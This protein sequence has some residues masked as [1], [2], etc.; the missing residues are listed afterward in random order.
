MQIVVAY[1]AAGLF[2]VCFGTMVFFF[3][4]HTW[5]W[6][7]MFTLM[8]AACYFIRTL[9]QNEPQ[10]QEAERNET[11]TVE[12]AEPEPHIQTE[13]QPAPE[14]AT[15]QGETS[16]HRTNPVFG[17]LVALLAAAANIATIVILLY[18][19]FWLQETSFKYD[20]GE[21]SYFSG[22]LVAIPL[23]VLLNVMS[24]RLR[25]ASRF[26][27]WVVDF[28]PSLALL[29]TVIA[30]AGLTILTT[31][32]PP[33]SFEFLLLLTG[34]FIW[35]LADVFYNQRQNVNDL[36]AGNLNATAGTVTQG[37]LPEQNTEVVHNVTRRI[38]FNDVYEQVQGDGSVVPMDSP[39]PW[40]T[41]VIDY[42]WVNDPPQ[43]APPRPPAASA[44]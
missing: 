13:P 12:P 4:D 36:L 30:I 6:L 7:L 19:M 21:I 1:A 17:A 23:L 32:R 40:L 24:A 38:R 14:G 27:R 35:G 28:I 16:M 34:L 29:L 2:L 11:P 15:E 25:P 18:R 8:G 39:D 26:F 5:F 41:Q 9:P 42:H 20:G 31:I 3:G 10:Q 33:Q 22:A 44:S 37:G 43:I